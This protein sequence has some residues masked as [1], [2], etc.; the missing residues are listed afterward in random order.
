MI[1]TINFPKYYQIEIN[2]DNGIVKV[3]SN[4]KHAKGRELSQSIDINGYLSVKMNNKDYKIHS[5][6]A[7]YFLGD[8]PKGLCINHIDSNKLNNAVSN[9]EYVTIRENILHAIKSG[10]HIC[11]RPEQ[12]G[13]YIDGRCKDIVSYKRSWYLQNRDRILLKLKQKNNVF[14]N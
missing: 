9:L 12:M 1:K 14:S 2:G 5:L 13:R 8:R 6:V 4:S 3:I 11:N 10:T 7:K